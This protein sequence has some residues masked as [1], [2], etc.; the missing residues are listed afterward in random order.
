MSPEKWRPSCLGHS[1]CSFGPLYVDASIET[2]L[3]MVI[4]TECVI[5]I[6]LYAHNS[7]SILLFGSIT[8]YVCNRKI[9]MPLV[10][11]PQRWLK[12]TPWILPTCNY[13]TERQQLAPHWAHNNRDSTTHFKLK[14]WW[15]SIFACDHFFFHFNT[16]MGTGNAVQ[17]RSF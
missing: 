15:L 3:V 2:I 7:S 4:L 16:I 17:Y 12:I 5:V 8:V 1:M 9:S 6:V 14:R 10:V 11:S 13:H